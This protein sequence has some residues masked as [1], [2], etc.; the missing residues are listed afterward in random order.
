MRRSNKGSTP[1]DGAMS[2]GIVTFLLAAAIVTYL[3]ITNGDPKNKEP[4]WIINN[5]LCLWLP[6]VVIMLGLRKDPAEFG[7]QV[8]DSRIGLRWAL[9]LWMGMLLLVAVVSARP[10]FKSYYLT[11]TLGVD[12]SGTGPV[13]EVQFGHGVVN[14]K[15]LAYYELAM[16]FYMFCWEFF[17]RGFLLFGLEKTWLRGV[18]AVIVQTIPFVL[19]HWSWNAGAAKPWAE[20]IGSA[21]AAPILGMLA[22][23]TR[24]FV[25]GFVAHWAVSATMDIFILAPLVFRHIG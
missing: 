24:S 2:T 10:E 1:G 4:Y 22:L 18:G 16:G 20:I 19:L 8:G 12:L 21:I 14:L 13:Y 25:Y 23:K 15:A 6:L 3:F 11:N 9:F 7:F 17:F 5:G